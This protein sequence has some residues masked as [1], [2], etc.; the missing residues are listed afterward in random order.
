M[1]PP[2]ISTLAASLDIILVPYIPDE[3]DAGTSNSLTAGSRVSVLPAPP[4]DTQPNAYSAAVSPLQEPWGSVRHQENKP[5]SPVLFVSSS[6]DEPVTL[7]KRCRELTPDCP[8]RGIR[9]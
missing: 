9:L 7:S 8:E 4:V 5:D 6:D 2:Q 1:H 3:W